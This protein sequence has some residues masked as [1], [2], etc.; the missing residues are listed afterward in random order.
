[1][2]S[3]ELM[4]ILLPQP[5]N[6]SVFRGGDRAAGP[7]QRCRSSRGFTTPVDLMGLRGTSQP[8]VLVLLL[9]R[10]GVSCRADSCLFEKPPLSPDGASGASGPRNLSC[11][12]VSGADYECSWQYDGSEDNVTH[13]LR[14]CFSGGRCCYFPAGHSRT[15]QFSEQAGVPVLST[16]TFWVE[17]RLSSWTMK[18]LEISLCLSEWSERPFTPVKF[19]PPLGDVRV[20][21]TEGQLRL[22][23]N[24][25]DEGPAE[26]QFRRRTPT[27]NWTLG[28]CG[29]QDNSG[30]GVIE[31]IHD[32][33]SESCLCPSENM[34]Q[35][36]QIRRR[37]RL[38]SGAPGGPWSSW[39]ASVCAPPEPFP[40]PEVKFLVEPLG[41]GGRRRLTMQGQSLQPAVPEG[42]EGVRP[43]AQARYLVRVHMLSCT[44]QLLSRKTVSLGKP[45]SLSGAAYD[46]VVLTRT[47]F[48]RSPYLTWHLP[49]QELT[50]MRT[51]NV[52]VEG[53]VTSLHWAAQAP[54]TTYCLEWQARG[55]GGNHTHCTLIAPG[56]GDPAG[57]VTHSWS[58]EPALDQEEC[59]RITVFA[60]KDPENP[61][62]W[63][64]L[65]SGY[66]FGGNASV[67]GTPNHVWVR[68]HSGNS[69]SVEWAPSR[70]SACP[71]VLTRY[72]VRCEAEDSEWVSEWLVPPTQT[73]V[74]LEGL[75]SGVVYKAQV[76]ADTARL[77]GSWSRPQRFSFEVQI[78]RLSII[79]ASLGSFASV[80]LVGGLGY[81]GLNRVAW[82]LC[83]PLPTP[84]ASTAVEFP[85]SQGKQAWQWRSPED[86]PEVLCPR[87][88]LVVEK[89]RDADDRTEPPQAAPALAL[90]TARSWEA[91]SQ[92]NGRPEAK[93][94]GMGKDCPRGGLAHEELP[95][96][97]GDVTQ[98][99]SAFGDLWWAPKTEEPAPSIRPSGP[100]H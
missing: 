60:S 99:A 38:S 71:G 15:V 95:L 12:R 22:D 56:D 21:R 83:P 31:D 9:C 52:S 54:D 23:W 17:S 63:Y 93:G 8:I 66:Y 81:I 20:S 44:C 51:L 50:G 5:P 29:P 28:D 27:A 85:G 87:E 37:R 77:V 75:R 57:K 78:S 18:S 91:G 94:L 33:I 16:V 1:M 30:L 73:Q 97:L 14:C 89:A 80:L 70:L 98:G 34:A 39:S 43:G 49:A 11:Y 69:V 41:R 59:Y 82:H 46:L 25:T 68:N 24:I 40:Q 90:A 32:S 10:L 4:A 96:L 36:F 53:N 47:R 88:T 72:V 67:A 7:L 62:L 26:V 45:L 58:S 64:T 76:R 100:E 92:V 61:V 2:A 35:E 42:C 86:F 84:C 3:L 19:S 65:L 55:Q 13:F 48:G 6:V 74:T 79:F